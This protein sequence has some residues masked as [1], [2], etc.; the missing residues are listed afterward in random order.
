M[1][2]RAIIVSRTGLT[3]SV[4]VDSEQA[5]KDYIANEIK[6]SADWN[7]DIA[8]IFI[9]IPSKRMFTEYLETDFQ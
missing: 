9:A 5:A 7:E 1:T 6:N 4:Q 2:V 8:R 3:S